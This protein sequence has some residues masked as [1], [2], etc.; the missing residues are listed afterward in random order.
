MKSET[1]LELIQYAKRLVKEKKVK[2]IGGPGLMGQIY[3]I[4]GYSVRVFTK[5]GRN[6]FSCDC[7][8]GTKFCN[9]PT[10]C[11]HKLATLLFEA[12]NNFNTKINKVIED[13]NSY[14]DN[15]LKI[16]PMLVIDDL[17]KLM[18]AK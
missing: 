5:K 4:D 17:N 11:V 3:D 15:K 2:K 10:F 14:Q 6:V 9:T 13:Y 18:E 12:D 1:M 8:H 7:Y 16:E